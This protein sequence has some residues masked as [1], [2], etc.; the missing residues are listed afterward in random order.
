MA[1]FSSSLKERLLG[2]ILIIL[3]VISNQ[4]FLTQAL[5][6][7]GVIEQTSLKLTIW[8]FDISCFLAGLLLVVFGTAALERVYRYASW[9]VLVISAALLGL[10]LIA[11]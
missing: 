11:L 10:W 3:G 7:D 8:I 1:T 2:A 6:P 4:W 9:G 5:S